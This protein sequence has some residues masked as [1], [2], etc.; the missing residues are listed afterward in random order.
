MCIAE[1][2]KSC[3]SCMSDVSPFVAMFILILFECFLFIIISFLYVIC[4]SY[5]LDELALLLLLLLLI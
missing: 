3:N 1:I 4:L 5:I 2:N